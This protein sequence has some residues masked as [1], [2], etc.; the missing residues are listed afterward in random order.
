MPISRPPIVLQPNVWTDIY[1]ITGDAA[2]T[3]ITFQNTGKDHARLSE[4]TT[5]PTS[6]VGYNNLLKDE[7]LNSS[8]APIGLF[9]ISRLGTVIQAELT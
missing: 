4:T 5:T 3:A 8:S 2:G 9:V 6:S 1:A 7:F